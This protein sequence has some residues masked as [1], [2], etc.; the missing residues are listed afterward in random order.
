MP[1]N[2]FGSVALVFA[3]AVVLSSSSIISNLNALD[4]IAFLPFRILERTMHKHRDP[5]QA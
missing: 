3:F 5:V 2:T 1:S 4:L